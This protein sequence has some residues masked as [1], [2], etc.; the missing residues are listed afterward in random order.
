MTQTKMDWNELK[1]LSVLIH[2][3][4]MWIEKNSIYIISILR[5]GLKWINGLFFFFN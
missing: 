2:L 1:F 3:N 5:H 4:K